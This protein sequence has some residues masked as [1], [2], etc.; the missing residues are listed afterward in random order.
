M[1]H[2]DAS[3]VRSR[4]LVTTRHVWNPVHVK[5]AKAKRSG[6]PYVSG[7]AAWRAVARVRQNRPTFPWLYMVLRSPYMPH[8][9]ARP[10]CRSEKTLDL[11]PTGN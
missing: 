1:R 4:W 5:A 6:R 10:L 2:T 11:F 3:E 8:C 7:F 9:I